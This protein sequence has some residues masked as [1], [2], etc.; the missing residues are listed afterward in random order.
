MHPNGR[1]DEDLRVQ[2]K[3]VAAE[4]VAPHQHVAIHSQGRKAV[5]AAQQHGDDLDLFLSYQLSDRG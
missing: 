4:R 5:I 2:P 1:G 3:Q